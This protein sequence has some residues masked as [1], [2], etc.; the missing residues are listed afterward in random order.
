MFQK[1]YWVCNNTI[2]LAD[3]IAFK[4]VFNDGVNGNGVV[5][6]SPQHHPPPPLPVCTAMLFFLPK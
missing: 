2:Y 3:K 5:V 1:L 6:L 4:R